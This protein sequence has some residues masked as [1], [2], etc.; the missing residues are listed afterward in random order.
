MKGK[1]ACPVGKLRITDKDQ[2]GGQTQPRKGRSWKECQWIK[3]KG[4]PGNPPDSKIRRKQSK[5]H[6]S[7]SG[8]VSVVLAASGT[9]NLLFPCFLSPWLLGAFERFMH[10]NMSYIW[11]VLNILM[12]PVAAWDILWCNR[13][14]SASKILSLLAWQ[15]QASLGK[16][17]L[18]NNCFSSDCLVGQ[19]RVL[20]LIFQTTRKFLLCPHIS[21]MLKRDSFTLISK[22]ISKHIWRH[23]FMI[24]SWTYWSAQKHEWSLGFVLQCSELLWFVIL[25]LS[26]KACWSAKK[27]ALNWKWQERKVFS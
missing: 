15:S 12:K 16:T 5:N 13:Y 26:S 14:F 19:C 6:F 8:F 27:R 9:F 23:N 18:W 22:F 3:W 7:P 10:E 2:E 20:Y 4:D 25:E 21:Q 17:T 11:Q 24:S 1:E